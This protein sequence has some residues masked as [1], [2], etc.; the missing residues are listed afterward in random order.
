MSEDTVS[1]HKT[2]PIVDTK[3]WKLEDFELHETLGTGTFG[4]VRLVKH[5]K[6][7]QYYAMKILKKQTIIRLKQVE[8][9]SNE[10]ELLLLVTSPFC[11]TLYKT[12]QDDIKLYMILEY[13]P[14]GELFTHIRK[15]GKFP[16]DVAK[17]YTAELVCA[18]EALHANEIVYRD[19]KPENVLLD[20]KGHVKLTDF[21]FAKQIKDK[22][23]LWTLCGTPEYLARNIGFILIFFSG[24][25]FGDWT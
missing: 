23:T 16:N 11:V 22:A 4:R 21:G 12:F 20:G 8:H 14:G 1:L 19:L 17:F 2:S 3:D 18:L 15:A 24:S 25:D 7:D 5:K 6:T 9:I 13:I 10:R